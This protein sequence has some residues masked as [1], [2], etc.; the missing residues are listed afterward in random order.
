MIL[1]LILSG[2]Q[3]LQDHF[4]N[5]VYKKA[6]QDST[7][8]IVNL[9]VFRMVLCGV[10]RSGKTTFW[11][12]IAIQDFKPSPESASTGAAESHII[13]AIERAHVHAEMLFDLHLYSKDSDLDSEALTIY[14][15]ILERHRPKHQSETLNDIAKSQDERIKLQTEPHKSEKES[16]A[17][18][19]EIQASEIQEDDPS[20]KPATDNQNTPS[21]D[22]Q[23]DHSAKE[24][25]RTQR[26]ANT[27]SK[28]QP[29]DPIIAEIRKQFKELHELQ[30]LKGE[31]LPHL[32]NIKKMCHLQDTGGQRAFLELLP[33]LSTGKALYLLFFN[34]KDFEKSVPETM[35]AKG[36]PEELPTGIEYEQIDVIVQSLICVSTTSGVIQSTGKGQTTESL[37][38]IALLVGTHVDEVTSE[39]VITRVNNILHKRVEPFFKK[40]EIV[41]TDS[42]GKRCLVLKVAIDETDLCSNKP[43]DYVKVIM[44]VV[45]NKLKS[46]ESEELP[47]SWYMFCIMLRRL[48]SAGYSV[49]LYSHCQHIAKELHIQQVESELKSILFRLQNVFGIVL[50][51]PEVEALED[52]VICDPAF[53][54]K[55]ISGLIFKTLNS[56]GCSDVSL[57]EENPGI[58]KYKELEK[59]CNTKQDLELSKLIILLEHLGIVAP[60]KRS[61]TAQTAENEDD[62]ANEDIIHPDQEYVIPCVLKEAKQDEL[63]VHLK[64]TQACSIVPLRIYFACG[65]APMGGFCYLFTKLIS[66]NEGWELCIPD[67]WEDENHIYWR[68]KVTLEVKH[69][70]HIYFVTLISTNEYYEIHILHSVSKPPF[71][72]QNDG[73]S[74]CK[75][76]WKAIHTILEK[77]PNKPLQTYEVA[78]I[79]TIHVT[80]K[81]VMKFTSKPHENEKFPNIK[82]K[83]EERKCYAPLDKEPS[84]MVWFKVRLMQT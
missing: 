68:N 57:P 77:S 26:S 51:F 34:Y 84:V 47:A 78:C 28:K 30:Q 50:Y 72:L 60:I 38:N 80:D 64:D 70:S 17:S 44:K 61:N 42:E 4:H 83:C 65:F 53:V 81:H 11:K 56:R 59:H 15:L 27:V 74:I 7:G 23:K 54:Y 36:S 41:H 18:K 79:C 82:A 14:K 13:S 63:N 62:P 20:L 49:L 24:A 21:D 29:S 37:N 22:I 55:S 1:L 35:Q 66:N 6:L 9:Q 69:D 46:K 67:V 43:E 58:F 39:D 12:R 8:H 48:Q 32:S 40:C 3:L 25:L 52:I 31:D 75:H 71:Q 5:N 76:V 33:T 10:P 45:N 16:Q 73:H 2:V 19:R